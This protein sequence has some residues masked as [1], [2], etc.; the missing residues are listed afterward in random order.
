M[1][2][3]LRRQCRRR[4]HADYRS[5]GSAASPRGILMTLMQSL[6]GTSASLYR[7]AAIA[8]RDFRCFFGIPILLQMPYAFSARNV[9]QRIEI[10]LR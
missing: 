8:R 3:L 10:D 9:L 1:L 5:V 2:L 4:Q 6:A 7:D